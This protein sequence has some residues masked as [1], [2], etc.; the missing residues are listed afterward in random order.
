MQSGAEW[1]AGGICSAVSSTVSVTI[2]PRMGLLMK[3]LPINARGARLPPP[4]PLPV[5]VMGWWAHLDTASP[6]P[7]P[8]RSARSDGPL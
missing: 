7:H 3:S 5:V 1:C 4:I 6:R 2:S 8:G